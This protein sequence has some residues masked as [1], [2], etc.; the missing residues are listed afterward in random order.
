[1]TIELII[2]IIIFAVVGLIIFKITKSILKAVFLAI[3]ALMIIL[4]I[5]TALFVSD[6]K[7][8][9]E[10]NNQMPSL[11]LLEDQNTVIAGFSG[12]SGEEFE[13]SYVT[14]EQ[15]AAHQSSYEKEDLKQILGDNYKLFIIT[16][17]LAD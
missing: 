3:S 10:K 4:F 6:V 15:L 5:F 9:Q 8:F 11:Y 7:D 14:A 2:L 16:K 1:M 12:I 17:Q 13:P